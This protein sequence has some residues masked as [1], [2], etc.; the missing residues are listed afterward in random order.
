MNIEYATRKMEK[1]LTDVRLVK[2]N[3][4]EHYNKIILR[5]SELLL[6]ECLQDIPEVPPPRRHKL[7]GELSNCWGIDYSKNRRI[8]IRP[9]GEYD[10]DNLSSIRSIEI[11]DLCDYH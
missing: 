7:S 2:K 5:L 10:I 8:I 9:I 6:A 4:G 3:Y 11:I 1:I